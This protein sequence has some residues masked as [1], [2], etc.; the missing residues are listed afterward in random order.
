MRR[1]S[2]I[3]PDKSKWDTTDHDAYF[4]QS[5]YEENVGDAEGEKTLS[6]TDCYNR[7]GDHSNVAR[8]IRHPAVKKVPSH[9]IFFLRIV[10]AKVYTT[11][12]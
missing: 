8:L 2:R 1:F 12:K 10:L 5:V 6:K 7:F 9:T 11:L 3:D 4:V